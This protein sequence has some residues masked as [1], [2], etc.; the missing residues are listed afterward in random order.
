MAAA[1][2]S[3]DHVAAM[4]QQIQRVVSREGWTHDTTA[5]PALQQLLGKL[6]TL[7]VDVALLKGTGIGAAV[8]K[9]TKHDDDVV[10]GY[11]ASLTRKWMEQVGVPPPPARSGSKSRDPSPTPSPSPSGKAADAQ[12][13][14]HARK[15]LQDGYASEKAKRDSRTVQVLQRPVAKGR[16][17]TTISAAPSRS[18]VAQSQRLMQQQRRAGG[19]APVSA[20]A[21]AQSGVATVR[22]MASPRA[23]GAGA[24]GVMSREEQHRLRQ[25]KLRALREKNLRENGSLNDVYPNGTGAVRGPRTPSSAGARRATTSSSSNNNNNNKAPPTR[26]QAPVSDRKALLNKMFPRVCGVGGDAKGGGAQKTPSARAGGA[27]T[28]AGGKKKSG[29][30]AAAAPNEGQREVLAWLRGLEVDMSEYAPAFFENGFDSIKLLGNVEAADLPGLIPKKGHH[31]LIQQALD[32]LKRKHRTAASAGRPASARR[33]RHP[34]AGK[35]RS[36]YSDDEHDSDDSFVVSDDDEY[37]PGMISGMFR[38]NRKRSYSIDSVDSYNM[39][40]SYDEIQHEE[41]R[42]ARYGEYEDY[43]EDLRNKKL[44]KKKKK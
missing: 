10:R 11:S 29:G 41:E 25:Q 14:E 15:R 18:S 17:G 3:A 24:S 39:E 7:K 26:E 2:A 40:A 33:D 35:R 8:R 37:R 20:A 44:L 36:A 5:A 32:D 43:R 31:R 42:S 16:K 38:K 23:P 21:R 9:L 28:A 12:R 6:T 27:A 30:A 34:S 19:G 22:M 1:T 13:L 4:A